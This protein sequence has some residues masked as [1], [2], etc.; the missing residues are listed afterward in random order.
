MAGSVLADRIP[1]IISLL[2]IAAGLI[3]TLV[4]GNPRLTLMKRSL[5]TGLFGPAFLDSLFLPCLLSFYL[6]RQM[7]TGG[8]SQNWLRAGTGSRFA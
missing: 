5:L 8:G 4:T 1:H 6:G 7:M 3:A 2:F